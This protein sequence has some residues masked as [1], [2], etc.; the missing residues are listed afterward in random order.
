M[1]DDALIAWFALTGL[2][3]AYVAWDASTRN[4]ELTVMKYGWV[5]VTLYAGPIAAALYVLSC[6]EPGPYQHESFIL[7]GIAE[8][9]EGIGLERRRHLTR[10]QSMSGLE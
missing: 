3:V 8:E 7:P 6:E 1:L 10:S 2:S 9:V 4:P 5:L